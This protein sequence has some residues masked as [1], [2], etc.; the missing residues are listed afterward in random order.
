MLESAYTGQSKDRY[1]Y[2]EWAAYE[3]LVYPE[4][5]EMSHCIPQRDMFNYYSDMIEDGYIPRF[6]EGYD[7]GIVVPSCYLAA[8]VDRH[9]NVF[10]FDGFHKPANELAIDKQQLEINAVRENIGIESAHPILADP[11]IFRKT[12]P[13]RSEQAKSVA[14]LFKVGEFGVSMRMAGAEKISGI[15]KVNQYL[16]PSTHHAHPITGNLE[17]PHLYIATELAFVIS[18]FT[19][20]YWK[21]GTDGERVDEPVN[22][23]DHAMDVIK[24]MLSKEPNLAVRKPKPRDMTWINKWSE[25]EPSETRNLARYG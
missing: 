10:I 11:A 19:A 13:H 2:G 23:N 8:F 22:K 25:R 15:T 16:S 9:R 12:M 20:Y 17:S 4:F 18:E 1:L 6:I 21:T 24:Y 14:E 5:N 7:Y 3:G